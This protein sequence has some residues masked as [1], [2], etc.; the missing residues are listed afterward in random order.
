[1]ALGGGALQSQLQF[2]F[3][4]PQPKSR[5]SGTDGGGES[6]MEVL[7]EKVLTVPDTWLPVP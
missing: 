1:M 4:A 3:L 7:G 6:G 5:W 2:P